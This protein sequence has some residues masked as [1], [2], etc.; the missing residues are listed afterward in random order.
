MFAM[1]TDV[2]I[3]NTRRQALPTSTNG[4]GSLWTPDE[5]GATIDDR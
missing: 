4:K 3:E 1:A 2:R 5:E